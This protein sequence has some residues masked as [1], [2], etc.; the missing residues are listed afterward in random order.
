MRKNVDLFRLGRKASLNQPFAHKK[1]Y[2]IDTSSLTVS[3]EAA[4][5]D[6]CYPHGVCGDSCN[7][8][9]GVF[10]MRERDFFSQ[11][12]S[13]TEHIEHAAP[14]LVECKHS[15][16]H[17][18][19]HMRLWRARILHLCESKAKS[20]LIVKHETLMK[21]YL[22][23]SRRTRSNVR[24][25]MFPGHKFLPLRVCLHTVETLILAAKKKLRWSAL[26][27]MTTAGECADT[28]SKE[29]VERKGSEY[30][31]RW[32]I[33]RKHSIQFALDAISERHDDNSQW[34]GV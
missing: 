21:I 33:S 23:Q 16:F 2:A 13:C 25:S 3:R 10:E 7:R 18:S 34:F 11:V 4:A 30:T 29:A 24:C 1:Y 19:T 26:E 9:F 20:T 28:F 22:S 12:K 8:R 5:R 27:P 17:S 6:I 32:K 15:T 14:S 31:N